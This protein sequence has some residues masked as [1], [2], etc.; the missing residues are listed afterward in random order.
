MFFRQSRALTLLGDIQAHVRPGGRAI[1]NVL[2]QGTTYMEMFAAGNYWLFGREEL[3]GHFSGW[4]I[5]SSRFDDFP[6]P[7]GTLKSFATLIARKSPARHIVVS[8]S[9]KV[10]QAE[11]V[12]G[13]L[14]HIYGSGV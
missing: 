12:D 6:A 5:E 11:L 7:G 9:C 2:V 3:A 10:D 13:L 8:R 4:V 14:A 1:V